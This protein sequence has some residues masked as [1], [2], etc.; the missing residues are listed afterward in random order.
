M[1]GMIPDDFDV[2][3]VYQD[4]DASLFAA[5]RPDVWHIVLATSK[6]GAPNYQ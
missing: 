6:K 3:L 1:L 5:R 4:D 2:A